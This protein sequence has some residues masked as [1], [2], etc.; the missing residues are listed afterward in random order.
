M[1]EFREPDAEVAVSPGKSEPH[2]QR[3][4]RR[5]AQQLRNQHVSKSKSKPVPKTVS[6]S[7]RHHKETVADTPQVAHA[8]DDVIDVTIDPNVYSWLLFLESV[9]TRE[10]A[11]SLAVALVI[12]YF[13]MW[14]D[15]GHPPGFN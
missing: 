9:F 8:E 12:L 3:R 4:S 15:L 5:Q 1:S 7:R 14:H 2:Q 10:N 6:T 11:G 13:I